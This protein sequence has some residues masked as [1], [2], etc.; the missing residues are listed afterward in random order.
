MSIRQERL[1]RGSRSTLGWQ[2][3]KAKQKSKCKAG[4]SQNVSSFPWNMI[5]DGTFQGAMVTKSIMC[6]HSAL[7]VTGP[8]ELPLTIGDRKA[9]Q[10]RICDDFLCF[11]V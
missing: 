4:K 5:K 6:I 8:W 11:R 7:T 9:T 10:R 2:K 1:H 3:I